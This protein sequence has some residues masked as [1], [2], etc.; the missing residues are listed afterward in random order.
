MH[1]LTSPRHSEC[2]RWWNIFSEPRWTRSSEISPHRRK[3]TYP[4]FMKHA[5]DP[6]KW[7]PSLLRPLVMDPAHSQPPLIVH[8][9]CKLRNSLKL[10]FVAIVGFSTVVWAL[11]VSLIIVVS[12]FSI[13]WCSE[14]HQTS[15]LNSTTVDPGERCLVVRRHRRRPPPCWPRLS[16]F[17]RLLDR[18]SCDSVSF[19]G[20]LRLQFECYCSVLAGTNPPELW[21]RWCSW[22][23]FCNRNHARSLIYWLAPR[24]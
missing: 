15:H 20:S 3:S 2:G 12:C 13:P 8:H 14:A 21:F 23:E 18:R 6:F 19:L 4:K 1:S 16:P 17:A 5:V 7:V 10:V 22:I 9:S 11:Q 24:V